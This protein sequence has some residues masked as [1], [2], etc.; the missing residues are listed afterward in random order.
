MKRDIR[1]MRRVEFCYFSANN[2]R[3]QIIDWNNKNGKFVST[4]NSVQDQEIWFS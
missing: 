4:G 3:K 1:E 2:S